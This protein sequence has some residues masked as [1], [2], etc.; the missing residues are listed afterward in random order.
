MTKDFQEFL[1]ISTVA[2]WVIAVALATLVTSSA[3]AAPLQDSVGG[4]RPADEVTTVSETIVPLTIEQ[5]I[6][7]AARGA[8]IDPGTAIRIARCESG[9]NPL[10]KNKH[11]S[12]TGLY[13][14]MTGTWQW[15]GAEAAGLD[16][17][18]EDDAIAMFIKWYPAHKGWWECK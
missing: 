11:S 10:A 12:A 5:K 8:G 3:R 15:I 2:F 17:K 4:S 16:R 13:Q 1:A 18:D 14:F 9:L 6:E 7:A